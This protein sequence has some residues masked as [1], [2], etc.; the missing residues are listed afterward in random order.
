MEG[1][2]KHHR[3]ANQELFINQSGAVA[4]NQK[5]NYQIVE[6]HWNSVFN[7]HATYNENIIDKIH[8][9]PV[10]HS[11]GLTPQ[12][13]KIRRTI[14]K[15]KSDKA[16]GTSQLTTNMLKNL[17]KDALTFVTETIQEFWQQDTDFS[18]WHITKL[19]ILYKGKGDP[20]DL[21]N[22]RGICL[23]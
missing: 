8:Q 7:R 20:Q 17:P 5:E 23:K 9:C 11:L 10:Q 16:P 14:A 2:Q 12:K 19:N 3:K 21:S 18:S 13:D 6:S 1:F 22:Y 15:M 4:A